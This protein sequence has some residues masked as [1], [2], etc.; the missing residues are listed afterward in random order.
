MTVVSK[1]I[2]SFSPSWREIV[3]STTHDDQSISLATI[4]L[5]ALPVLIQNSSIGHMPAVITSSTD[6]E[7]L[8]C[9]LNWN[10]PVPLGQCRG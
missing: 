2:L 6:T 4:Y 3:K 1:V 5:K 10:Q 9:G 8:D 7:Y